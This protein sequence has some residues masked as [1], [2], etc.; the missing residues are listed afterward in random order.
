MSLE[1][2]TLYATFYATFFDAAAPSQAASLAH[3][4][5]GAL[6]AASACLDGKPTGSTARIRRARRD[7]DFWSCA[8][9]HTVP[10]E[11]WRSRVMTLALARYFAPEDTSHRLA[12]APRGS[13]RHLPTPIERSFLQ[14]RCTERRTVRP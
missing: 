10:V 5:H 13:S 1:V 3:A 12:R 9:W 2:S 14:S 4:A 6:V 7:A 8:H 11:T